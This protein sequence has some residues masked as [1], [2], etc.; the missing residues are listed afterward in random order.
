MNIA[1]ANILVQPTFKPYP[2]ACRVCGKHNPSPAH[3]AECD[4]AR[5]RMN[6]VAA[7]V[8]N[9]HLDNARGRPRKVVDLM[10]Y[11]L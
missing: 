5:E 2:G 7:L 10:D 11:E 9:P 3:V 4:A 1:V 8:K 6:A